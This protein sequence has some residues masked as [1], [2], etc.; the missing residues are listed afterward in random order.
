LLA[1][2]QAQLASASL[3][4]GLNG[5]S[6]GLKNY[7]TLFDFSNPQSLDRVALYRSLRRQGLTDST[8]IEDSISAIGETSQTVTDGQLA[9]VF[10]GV[11]GDRLQKIISQTGAK[12][13]GTPQTLNDL[14]EPSIMMPPGAVAAM[15]VKPGSGVA[16]LQSLGNTM[17]NIGV[18][19]DNVSASKLLG[20]VQTNVGGYLSGLT[21]L[22]PTSVA[23]ALSPFL[24]SGSGPF[25]NPSMSDMMGSVSGK[26]TADF[27]S[28]A[29]QISGI[30]TSGVG[31]GLSSAMTALMAAVTSGSGITSALAAFTTATSTFNAQAL[32]NS[33]LSSALSS[34]D[35]SM[36]NVSSHLSL[37]N[38]NLAQAGIS[39]LSGLSALNPSGSG[40][41]LSFASKLH[42]FGVDKLQLGHNDIFNG[43]ATDDLHGDA[44]KAALLE[45]KNVAAMASAGKSAPS[46]SDTSAAL[47]SSNADNIDSFISAFKTAK[48]AYDSADAN[49]LDLK[50]QLAMAL[51]NHNNNPNMPELE[52]ELKTATAKYQTALTESNSAFSAYQDAKNKMNAAAANAPSSSGAVDKVTAALQS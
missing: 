13:I 22:V 34:I 38:S 44:L 8:G 7:G 35:T 23:S 15:G 6:T 49:R 33:G 31:Q 50:Q 37:E 1:K 10:R 25:G 14:L 2:G 19:M 43:V 36:T 26:H 21:S 4:D 39:N 40:Q 48:S 45:G 52:E 17:T 9:V 20:G 29:N 24:G 30:A 16:G 42:S 41:V 47:S 11:T 18:P 51:Q 28:A 27:S 46:V 3:S 32:G 12:P 5:V